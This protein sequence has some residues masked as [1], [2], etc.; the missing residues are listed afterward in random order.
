[1][2]T[3][4]FSVG[5]K[6]DRMGRMNKT[7]KVWPHR[8]GQAKRR[9]FIRSRCCFKLNHPTSPVWPEGFSSP[10]VA[11]KLLQTCTDVIRQ[12]NVFLILLVK[13]EL[14]EIL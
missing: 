14:A 2:A 9:E 3:E 6:S 8:W 11:E 12:E 10:Q 13:S 5:L 1:V 7:M 4:D